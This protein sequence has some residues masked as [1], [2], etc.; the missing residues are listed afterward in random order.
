LLLILLSISF[1]AIGSFV[2]GIIGVPIAMVCVYLILTLRI[3]MAL[4]RVTNVG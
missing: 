4:K 2:F 1:I 3:S